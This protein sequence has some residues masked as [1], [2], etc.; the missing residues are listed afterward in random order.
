M[1][2]G[3]RVAAA[4]SEPVDKASD[5]IL[6]LSPTTFLCDAKGVYKVKMR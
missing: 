2:A 4:R 3:L 5:A 1:I 6:L